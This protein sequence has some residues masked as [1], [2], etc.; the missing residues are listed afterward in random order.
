MGRRNPHTVEFEDQRRVELL[1]SVARV[2]RRGSSES[3]RRSSCTKENDIAAP[4]EQRRVDLQ[5]NCEFG[6]GSSAAVPVEFVRV[7]LVVG[8][9]QL[10]GIAAALS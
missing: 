10:S 1:S 3:G 7:V 8:E 4:E 5:L 9:E 2:Y 6:G